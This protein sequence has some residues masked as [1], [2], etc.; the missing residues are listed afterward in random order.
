MRHS[1][2][3][4]VAAAL[5]LTFG[6][7]ILPL[8]AFA[9]RTN[10]V[11]ETEGKNTLTIS[12]LQDLAVIYNDGSEQ[13]RNTMK[14]LDVQEMQLRNNRRSLEDSIDAMNSSGSLDESADGMAQME[15]TLAGLEA[16]AQ[17]DPTNLALQAS[18]AALRMQ[19]ETALASQASMMSSMQSSLD[20]AL[21]GIDQ[22]NDSL[23]QLA[24]SKDDLNKTMKDTESQM[25]YLA[26][27]LG[28]SIV[29]MDKGVALIE[30]QIALSEKSVQIA[31]LQQKLGMNISTDVESQTNDLQQAKENLEEQKETRSNLKRTLNILIGRNAGNPLEVTPM[32]LPTTIESA[33]A[34][35]EK[36]IQQFTDNNYK[37]KTL[38]R[39]KVNLRNSV[40]EDMGSDDRQM[41][42]YQIADK[43]QEIETQK[44]TVSDDLKAMLAAINSSGEAYRI[45]QQ[46]YA[47]QQK[48]Y[49]YMQK[50]YAL[51]MI[52]QIQLQSAELQLKQAELTNMQNG[53]QYYLNWQRY[54]AAEDGVDVSSWT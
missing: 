25:R 35:T 41:I 30:Q 31:Q 49:S 16:A 53:Y 20:S 6:L 11:A 34:Y 24:D 28:L 40:K 37:L 50:R 12:Q 8:P 42:D 1:P 23:D 14:Q 3:K 7:S 19:Y 13:L 52:S 21:D 18:T 46:A 39:D 26:A 9:V 33:P 43:D 36:L 32:N 15:Q 27:Q 48:E 44:Q 54:N 5:V 51:G 29:Q 47:T 17:A 38:E 2:K 45:S 22:L 4:V 10:I